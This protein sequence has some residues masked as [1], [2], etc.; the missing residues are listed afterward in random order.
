MTLWFELDVF[1]PVVIFRFCILKFKDYFHERK[2]IPESAK[3]MSRG[4]KL[5]N[6]FLLFREVVDS[7]WNENAFK[8]IF[9]R[10]TL[11]RSHYLIAPE[12]TLETACSHLWVTELTQRD[13]N[14][15]CFGLTS[16][17]CKKITSLQ[18]TS[19]IFAFPSHWL[20]AY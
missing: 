4:Y 14:L 7:I 2:A 6:L 8:S 1:F 3:N 11:I 19:F 16:Q 18:S 9:D 12:F 10:Y 13:K 15:C 17:C 20:C 5:S